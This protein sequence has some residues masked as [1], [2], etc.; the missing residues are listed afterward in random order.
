MNTTGM[1]IN[2]PAIKN[3]NND[4]SLQILIANTMGHPTGDVFLIIK[5][6]VK[7]A[8]NIIMFLSNL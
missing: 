7:I 8:V 6:I 1:N 5:P 3:D 4:L 2:K